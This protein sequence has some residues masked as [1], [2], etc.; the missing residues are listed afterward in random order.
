MSDKGGVCSDC[1][2]FRLNV[3][4]MATS[5]PVAVPPPA[6]RP[7]LFVCREQLTFLMSQHF[8]WQES[9]T[10]LQVSVKT[11]Q[12][13]AK[14]W[15]I[16]KFSLTSDS[17]LDQA[18]GE[19]LHECPHAGEAVIIGHLRSINICVQRSRI[20]AAVQRRTGCN[21]QS[22]HQAIV[23][24]TYDVSGPNALW[25]VDGNHKMIRWRLVVHGG[26]DGFSRLITFLWCSNNNRSD[27]VLDLFTEATHMYG[28]PSRI[29]TDHGGENVLIWQLMEEVGGVGRA[30]YI[31]GSSVHNTRIERLWRDVYTAVTTTY[32]SIFLEL[33]E[34]NLLDPGNEAD[35][36]CLHYVFIP[37]IN[38]TLKCFA[39]SWN[40]HPLSTENN[41]SPLQLYTANSGQSNLFSDESDCIDFD[42]YGIDVGIQTPEDPRSEVIIPDTSI[43]LSGE[44]I[45]AFKSTVYPLRSC[46]DY[47]IQLYCECV[48]VVYSLMERDNLLTF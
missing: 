5:L 6:G 1:A 33:E 34:R 19:Y 13:R 44:S 17:Q 47:G 15:G 21:G 8:S 46:N 16:I 41:L 37:R 38:S 22:S 25:H 43:P 32:V 29:R 3:Y 10:I 45:H 40:S 27:T 23:R 28:T 14:E 48:A 18:I 26:I 39:S 35:L 7:R 4:K 24:R 30:S 42:H 31:A 11:L 36:F 2:L 9:A 12:R 20:R